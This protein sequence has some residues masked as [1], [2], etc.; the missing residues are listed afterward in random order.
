LLQS[1]LCF[2][3]SVLLNLQRSIGGNDSIRLDL[4]IFGRSNDHLGAENTPL[5]IG[6]MRTPA[7]GSSFGTEMSVRSKQTHIKV[8]SSTALQ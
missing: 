4:F 7:L 6:A 2:S 5:Q 8:P 3:D 1:K